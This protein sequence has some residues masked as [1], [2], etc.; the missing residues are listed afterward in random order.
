MCK[1]CSVK[2][3]FPELP[4]NNVQSMNVDERAEVIGCMPQQVPLEP[5]VF[6]ERVCSGNED[7][8]GGVSRYPDRTRFDSFTPT[9]QIVGTDDDPLEKILLATGGPLFRHE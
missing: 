5:R 4:P 8:V 2:F 3:F 7:E 1:G 6:L 9:S